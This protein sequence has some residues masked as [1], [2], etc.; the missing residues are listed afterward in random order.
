MAQRQTGLPVNPSQV[1]ASKRRC[2]TYVLALPEP[3]SSSQP[4][5]QFRPSL[6]YS[7]RWDDIAR[8]CGSYY[9]RIFFCAGHSGQRYKEIIEII[10]YTFLRITK[11]HTSPPHFVGREGSSASAAATSKTL[12][13]DFTLLLLGTIPRSYFLM[14]GWHNLVSS[15]AA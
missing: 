8:S 3:G 15:I 1:R 5:T 12:C 13:I 11:T 2:N 9:E 6:A 4:T 14:F 7:R 10:H